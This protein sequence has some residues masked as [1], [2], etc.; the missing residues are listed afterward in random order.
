MRAD[1]RGL[2]QRGKRG[3]WYVDLV[4]DGTRHA[5]STKTADIATACA[6]RDE[7][8]SRRE[9]G[10]VVV[11]AVP[12]FGELAKRVVA[13]DLGHLAALTQRDRAR[14]LGPEGPI[15]SVLGPLA[16]DAIKPG[17]LRR[18]WVRAIEGK[19]STKTGRNYL[20]SITHVYSFAR[21]IG[22]TVS[23]PVAEFRQ[24]LRRKMR[25]QRG[26]AESAAGRHVRP[27]ESVAH[28]NALLDGAQQ[29]GLP[30]LVAVLLGLDAGL[31]KGET[32]GLRWSDVQWRDDQDTSRALRIE[33][34]ASG[35][36]PIGPTKSG[37]A[38]TVA[39]SRRLR[40]ALAALY[41]QRFEPGPDKLVL[42]G[43]G[44]TTFQNYW[45]RRILK[46][47]G[48]AKI[49][50]KD[51]RDT[52]ASQ[53]ITCGVPLGYVSRQLGHADLAVTAQHYAKWASADD[54]RDPLLRRP[55]E[56]PADFLAR[57]PGGESQH[58]P[59]TLADQAELSPRSSSIALVGR[60]GLEPVTSAV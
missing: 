3:I 26:R 28:I 52:F 49:T 57:L 53:L 42:E 43:V 20:D 34:S 23:S 16:L 1:R 11:A 37:R 29:E 35:G 7:F 44:Y 54:Y 38:R 50:Y 14:E 13:E 25:T 47:A 24:T 8:L 4:I 17:D 36:G 51:L 31:R 39:L 15:L 46:R 41:R 40:A 6:V 18:W 9:R 5:F 21:E 56:V 10:P 45:W 12:T 32:W 19:V 2:F 60:T 55:G 59:N 58:S 33:R 30:A 27:I 22:I 48:L